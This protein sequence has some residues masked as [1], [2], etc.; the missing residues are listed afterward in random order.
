MEESLGLGNHLPWLLTSWRHAL[1][2][3]S[4]KIESKLRCNSAEPSERQHADL[5]CERSRSMLLQPEFVTAR[6][7]SILHNCPSNL[8]KQHAAQLLHRGVSTAPPHEGGE[9][10]DDCHP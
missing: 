3:T 6:R 1:Y 7:P 10:S 4:E 5:S 9:L 8:G 2:A